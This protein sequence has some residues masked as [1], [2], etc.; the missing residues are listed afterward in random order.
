MKPDTTK[1]GTLRPDAGIAI[2]YVAV[3][4]LSSLWFVSLAIDMGKL[5]ATRTELQNA[6]DAAALAGA[7]ALD[8]TTGEIDQDEARARAA[9][10]AA[11]N[12]AFEQVPTPVIINPAVDVDFPPGPYPR[13]RVSVHR[14]R[15]TGNPMITH[16]A[17]TVGLSSLNVTADATAEARQL[18]M[19]CEG[20]V[21]FA[22][23]ELPDDRDFATEC[24]SQYV[25]KSS[26]GEGQQGNY[27]L[28][29]FPDCNEDEFTGGGGAAIRHYTANGY[30]CCEELGRTMLVETKTGNTIGPFR[31][32]LLDRWQQDT[33]Q[34]EG[35]CYEE[36][37]N[38][39]PKGS[40]ERVVLTPIIQTFDVN[41]TK[42]VRI[43][44]FAAFFLKRRPVGSGLNMDLY[45]QFIKYIAPGEFGTGEVDSGIYG[46]HLVE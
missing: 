39:S 11:S 1:R 34:T 19:V 21:P 18:R 17:Q 35:I 44:R 5:M 22:P 40:G 10:A 2:I 27:Q 31:Q 30:D 15:D 14:T 24:D 43:E 41:G 46:I 28:L 6:A 20:L 7:S 13:V 8:P 23:Q 25:L 4:L 9:A 29:R 42:Y 3:F 26:A 12:R 37:I 36:Y 38:G 45:G 33:N 32:G 16:F